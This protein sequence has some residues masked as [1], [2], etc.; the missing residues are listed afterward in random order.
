MAT[1]NDNGYVAA[2]A[3]NSGNNDDLKAE[4]KRIGQAINFISRYYK[5]KDS[6]TSLTVNDL[7][8]TIDNLVVMS[9][10]LFTVVSKLID[11]QLDNGQQ[12]ATSNLSDMI[13]SIYS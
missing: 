5:E 13:K 8:L 12:P 1:N 11:I 9:R 10:F 2:A 3:T 6:N 7:E 4:T